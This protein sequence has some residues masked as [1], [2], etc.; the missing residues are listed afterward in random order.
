MGTKEGGIV[1]EKVV[2]S[3][4]QL[5]YFAGILEGEGHFG[6]SDIDNGYDITVDVVN[7]SSTLVHWL[8][9]NIGGTV[10]M[11]KSG[12]FEW[13]CRREVFVPILEAIKDRLLFKKDQ[14]E[15]FLALTSKLQPRYQ[16]IPLTEEE[17]KERRKLFLEHRKLIRL[18]NEVSSAGIRKERCLL[19]L[20]GGADST[21]LLYYL[22]KKGLQCECV[23]FYYGQQ[24]FREVEAAKSICK[25]LG[26]PH[27]VV[28][29]S[30]AMGSITSSAL[31]GGGEIPTGHYTDASM[32]KT[33][34]P[35]RNMILMSFLASM[36]IDRG[37]SNIAFGPHQGDFTIYP[38]CRLRFVVFLEKAI[39]EGNYEKLKVLVPF[40]NL[41][42]GE[43]IYIGKKLKV[44]Y[45]L[46][47]TCYKGG[48]KACGKCG[49]CVERREA[50][51]KA[52]M[53]DPL[54]YE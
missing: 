54:E 19:S 43:I 53:E 46:T 28:D 22:Q 20:S 30:S 39:Q 7:S 26:I 9:E 32:R 16:G 50:F 14:C 38:D 48:E 49:S 47:W 18:V 15:T 6:V 31:I 34:V 29:I 51:E 11:D 40:L 23:S 13:Y 35:N 24:H 33:V 25:S 1:M 10:R 3:E 37:I 17:V 5:G 36:A 45:E 21:T 41:P 44:P 52:K 27:D 2:L 8:E 12:H 4:Y 42:K